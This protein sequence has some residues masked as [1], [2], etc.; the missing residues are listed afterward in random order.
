MFSLTK[1]AFDPDSPLDKNQEII[2]DSG[3]LSG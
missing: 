1:I 3:A 2:L